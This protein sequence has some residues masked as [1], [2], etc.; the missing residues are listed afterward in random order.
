M[1][2]RVNHLKGV[3]MDNYF[4][5]FQNKGIPFMEGREKGNLKDVQNTV[6]H[7]DD[8]GFING[9]NGEFAVVSFKESPSKFYFANQVITDMLHQVD[10]DG[11]RAEL[12]QTPIMFYMRQ[13]KDE[14]REYMTFEFIAD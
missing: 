4:N 8:F 11:M 5:K 2:G 7:I 10:A 6:L 1:V 3:T 14:K 9:S 13:S 12:A